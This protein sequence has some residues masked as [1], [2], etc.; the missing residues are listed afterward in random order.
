MRLSAALLIRVRVPLVAGEER[1]FL[2]RTPSVWLRWAEVLKAA[3]GELPAKPI[4]L[5]S[6]N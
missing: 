1:G 5:V 6:Y 4:A 3:A 2:G